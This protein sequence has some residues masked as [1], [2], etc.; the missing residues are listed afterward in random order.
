MFKIFPSTFKVTK[1]EYLNRKSS[2]T[3]VLPIILE[4][5]ACL[6]LLKPQNLII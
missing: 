5:N 6:Q 4:S 3:V 2:K 1:F